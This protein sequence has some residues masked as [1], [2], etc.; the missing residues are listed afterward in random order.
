VADREGGNFCGFFKLRVLKPNEP[1][2]STLAKDKLASVFANLGGAAA[3]SL[4]PKS[5]D[6]AK[7]R[8]EHAFKSGAESGGGDEP[9]SSKIAASSPSSD[10]PKK[11]LDDLFKKK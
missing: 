5:A 2:E 7:S 6:D 4:I 1:D 10:D 3:P 11:R 9:G 8:L